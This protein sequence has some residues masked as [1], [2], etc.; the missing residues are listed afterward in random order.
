V[1]YKIAGTYPITAAYSGDTAFTASTGSLT[2]VVGR[3]AT[4]ATTT[5]VASSANPSVVGQAVTYTATV[6]PVPDGGTVAF[7]DNGTPIA[8]CSA[9]QVAA[10]TGT[11]T[12]PVSYKIAG[13]YPI[14]A[15][16]SGDTAFTAST[17][18]LTQVVN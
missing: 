17:G 7:S 8:G 4:T 6:S 18:S 9:Q 1:S 3:A 16:Y 14:T 13:T 2:Q 11:A 10:S 15:A 12:C 5:T